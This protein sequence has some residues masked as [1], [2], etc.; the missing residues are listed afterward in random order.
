MPLATVTNS[1]TIA[2]IDLIES[3]SF[4]LETLYALQILEKKITEQLQIEIHQNVLHTVTVVVAS[5]VIVLKFLL[6]LPPQPTDM[7][8][9]HLNLPFLALAT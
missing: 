1:F 4:V 3:S 5:L 7:I 9:K 8:E 6:P 2:F